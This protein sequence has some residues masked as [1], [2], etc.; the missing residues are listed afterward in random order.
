M[1]VLTKM[2]LIE[3]FAKLSNKF[4]IYISTIEKFS[5]NEIKKDVP[6][7]PL[8]ACYLLLNTFLILTFDT[9]KEMEEHFY[10]ISEIDTGKVYA[11]TCSNKGEF[12]DENT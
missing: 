10:Q 3:K 6:F 2:D 8:D 7:L 5:I 11:L 12:L 1:K 4:C 9:E